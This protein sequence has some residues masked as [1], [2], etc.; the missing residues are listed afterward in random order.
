MGYKLLFWKN[1]K[2]LRR[3]YSLCLITAL[4]PIILFSMIYYQQSLANKF[5]GDTTKL[6]PEILT[7]SS[8]SSLSK[9]KIGYTHGPKDWTNY[10]INYIKSAHPDLKILSYPELNQTEF[11]KI[12]SSEVDDKVSILFC[13]EYIQVGNSTI[14]CAV[15]NTTKSSYIYDLIYDYSAPSK[16]ITLSPLQI[17]VVSIK[18]LLDNALL[19]Y[20]SSDTGFQALSVDVQQFPVLDRY[21][22]DF[23]LLS[24]A[25]ATFFII[26]PLL[27]CS[28]IILEVV[29]EKSDFIKVYLDLNGSSQF[30]YWG[31]WISIGLLISILCS[32]LL[33]LT[34]MILNFEEFYNMPSLL[35][36]I[37]FLLIN[38]SFV[39]IGSLV[40]C[41]VSNLRLANTLILAFIMLGVV[42]E[43]IGCNP[44]LIKYLYAVKSKWWA[45]LIRIILLVYPPFNFAIIYYKIF[46]IAGLNF[47]STTLAWVEGRKVVWSD[48][49]DDDY[50][51]I[52]GMEYYV[53]SIIYNFLYLVIFIV[54]SIPLLW[55]LDH[56]IPNNRSYTR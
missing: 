17:E 14:P 44:F 53:P 32:L 12:S 22:R 25:G 46:Q 30:D 56:V 10:T 35:I 3:N 27:I 28:L 8:L 34:G 24:T 13:T 36:F 41:L 18:I 38:V 2:I 40:A 52:H 48:I 16:D 9:L 19:N 29:R 31:S 54:F 21:I 6:N 33:P 15:S 49:L 7:S 39:M 43:N 20:S 50:G 1:T 55:Y 11:L 23:N 26:T 5:I 37:L 47:D 51:N 45:D 4:S 42:I